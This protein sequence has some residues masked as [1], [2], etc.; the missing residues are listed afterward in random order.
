M[1]KELNEDTGFQ[2]S[3]KTLIGIGAAMATVI[4]MWFMLQADIAEARELP[5]PPPQD[6]TRMEFDM[7][8]QMIRNTIMTTQSDVEEIKESLEKIEDKLYNR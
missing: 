3:I 6:V 8:D 2:I 7:K 5:E 4:S 1:V